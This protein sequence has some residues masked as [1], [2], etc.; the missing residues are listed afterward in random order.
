MRKDQITKTRNI[1][2]EGIDY[3]IE[4]CGNTQLVLFATGGA[5][6]KGRIQIDS[7]N[8]GQ[9]TREYDD[10]GLIRNPFQ[11]SRLI[12]NIVVELI[13]EFPAASLV[14]YKASTDRKKGPYRRFAKQ[15]AEKLSV[16]YDYEPT[17]Y[18]G[19]QYIRRK[20][21]LLMN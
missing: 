13:Y 14:S 16:W 10:V 6:K 20:Q 12:H 4:L 1:R 21:K 17:N 15:L 3:T 19:H 5:T 11:L 8:F 9:E 18:G 7:W 2:F